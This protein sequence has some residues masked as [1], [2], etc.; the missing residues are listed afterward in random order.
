M[1]AAHISTPARRSAPGTQLEQFPSMDRIIHRRGAPPRRWIAWAALPVLALPAGWLVLGR[2][3]AT[4][5]AVDPDRLTTAIVQRGDFVEYYPCDGTVEP[6]TSVYLDVE[7]GGRVDAIFA[8]AGQ[9]VQMGDLILRFSNAALQRTAIDTESQLLYN[10]DIQRNTQFSR[11]E[12]SLLLKEGLLELDHQIT[13]LENR[14]HRYDILMR[15]GSSPI[16][17]EQFETTRDELHYLRQRRALMTERMRQEDVLSARQMAQVKKSIERLDTSMDLLG[18]IVK[19][20][21][22][23][24]PIGGY[25]ST[26]DAQVGQS[27][28]RGQRIGQIDVLDRLKVRARIDQYYISRVGG[29]T[30]GRVQQDGRSYAVRVAKIYPEVRDGT[31][32]ADV[33]FVGDTPGSLKRGQTLTVEL[34]FGTHASGLLVSRGGFFQD[35]A[36]RWVYLISGDGRSA[37]RVPVRLGRQNPRQVEVLEGLRQG[38][39]IVTSSYETFNAVDELQFSPAIA[40]QRSSQ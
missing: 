28:P 31:F 7:E 16:S 26:I 37:R 40:S 5:L 32:E 11:A 30:T 38:D 4:R 18:R 13:D 34:S 15:S 3:A 19:S 36:G 29:E 2:P 8:E 12:S 27:I 23:R 24:A 1:Q 9:R 22:V 6:G 25:L 14:F 21:E 20:L 33:V 35:T 39:R 17:V 10:L